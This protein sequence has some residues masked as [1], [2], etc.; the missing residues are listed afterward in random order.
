MTENRTTS[1]FAKIRYNKPIMAGYV[2]MY[3]WDTECVVR[4]G[5]DSG[6]RTKHAYG[7]N[8]SQEN[9]LEYVQAQAMQTRLP[10]HRNS[11]PDPHGQPVSRDR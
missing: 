11:N 9:A 10:H 1:E 5:V 7:E 6:A 8:K 3:S 4:V 2:Y